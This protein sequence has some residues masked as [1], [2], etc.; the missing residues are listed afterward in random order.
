MNPGDLK[1]RLIFQ[2]P[3]GTDEN[4]YPIPGPIEYTKAWASLTTLQGQTR[5]VAA[6][7]QMEHSRQFS[8]RYQRKLDHGERPDNLE[9]V[10]RNQVHEI[11][12]IEDDDG[13]RKTMTV[14]GKAVS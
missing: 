4:G 3:G 8:I 2:Q 11:E 9:F 13:L 12:S 1:Q 6:Q 10:W 7:S 14:I 5:F